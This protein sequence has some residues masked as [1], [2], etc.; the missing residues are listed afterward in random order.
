MKK[1]IFVSALKAYLIFSVIFLF[2]F[3]IRNEFRPEKYWLI[4]IPVFLIMYSIPNTLFLILMYYLNIS[5]RS[6][7]NVK[8]VLIECIIYQFL[9]DT[10][11]LYYFMNTGI[12]Q[13]LPYLVII[14]LYLIKK[15]IDYVR[16]KSIF[17]YVLRAYLIFSVIFLSYV[18]FTKRSEPGIYRL[19][20]IPIVLIFFSIPNTLFL[21]IM[22][23]LNISKRSLL[24]VRFVLAECL[25]YLILFDTFKYYFNIRTEISK[26]LPYLVI[27][28]LYLIK[29]LIDHIRKSNWKNGEPENRLNTLWKNIT[30]N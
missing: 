29:K 30:L 26:F 24:N 13:F 23:Y 8:F 7:L 22:Y 25:I 12:S 4:S 18:L 20:G 15:L 16:K 5:K 9:F 2:D 6:L 17:K 28:C 27:T 3:L 1:N 21:L 11:R 19:V 14:C 10:F